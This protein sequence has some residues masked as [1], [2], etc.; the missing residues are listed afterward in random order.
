MIKNRDMKHEFLDWIYQRMINVHNEDPNQDYMIRFRS[1]ITEIRIGETPTRKVSEPEFK[2]LTGAKGVFIRL[3]GVFLF[4]PMS[5]VYFILV[6]AFNP[7]QYVLFGKSDIAKRFHRFVEK[8][9]KEN[10]I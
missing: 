2:K 4:I 9:I 1:V 10:G 3:L 7:T 8:L 6:M 5:I